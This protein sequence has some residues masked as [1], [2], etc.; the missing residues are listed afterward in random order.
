MNFS[1]IIPV[2]NAER[3]LK[4][5]LTSVT[6]LDYPAD[7][8]EIICVDNGSTDVSIKIIQSFKKVRL[9]LEHNR[10]SSYAARNAGIQ[11]ADGKL[12]A[13]TDADCIVCADWLLQLEQAFEDPSV[14]GV[15]GQI[16]PAEPKTFIERYQVSRRVL[17]LET[18]P[19]PF[20]GFPVT[21]NAAYRSEIFTEIGLF[22]E[23]LMSC[24][25]FELG[26][27]IKN[28]SKYKI[29]VQLD[30]AVLHHH[31]I[32]LPA[33]IGQYTRYGIGRKHIDELKIFPKPLSYPCRNP[34]LYGSLYF[35]KYLWSSARILLSPFFKGPRLREISF[36]CLDF[37]T[38]LTMR[39]AYACAPKIEPFNPKN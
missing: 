26:Q 20:K 28:H 33:M 11:V 7:Q 5:C 18:M 2:F 12:L 15:A 23:Q 29:K 31:R 30:I 16:L 6:N 3:T 14:G 17:N 37:L 8:Y 39:I 9:I 1:I 24:G 4:A 36:L 22:H 34:W 19:F 21:A 25:D 27:R 35:F 13:F 10:Q 32:S 38:E